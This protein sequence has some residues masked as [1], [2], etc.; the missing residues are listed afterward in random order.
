V[1]P[2]I[3]VIGLAALVGAILFVGRLCTPDRDVIGTELP[4]RSDWTDPVARDM[5]ERLMGISRGDT[6]E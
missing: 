3:V 6:R 1:T 2:I 5:Y 4:R